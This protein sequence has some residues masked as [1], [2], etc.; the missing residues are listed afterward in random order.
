MVRTSL[1]SPFVMYR[2]MAV[3]SSGLKLANPGIRPL[4]FRMTASTS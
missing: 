1:S 3:S 4:P 2:V